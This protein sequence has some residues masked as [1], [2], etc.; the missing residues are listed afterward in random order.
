MAKRIFPHMYQGKVS[1]P[2]LAMA[3]YGHKSKQ[4][5]S[6]AQY[7][8]LAAVAAGQPC[9]YPR[10]MYVHCIM[11]TTLVVGRLT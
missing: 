5:S 3:T 2:S 6:A 8:V 7:V 4:S 1:S 9:P 10:A 11:T